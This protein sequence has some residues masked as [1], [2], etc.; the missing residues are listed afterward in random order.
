MIEFSKYEG[1]GNDFVV[2]DARGWKRPIDTDVV[3]QICD[4]HRGIGADGIL[5]LWTHSTDG[6]EMKVQN[7]DGSDAGMCGNGMRCILRFLYDLDAVPDDT[8][9]LELVVSGEA[10]ACERVDPSTFLVV[11]GKPLTAHA[12][13]PEKATAGESLEFMVDQR[14]FSGRCH[15]FG[16]PHVTIFTDEDPMS[17]AQEFGPLLES[18]SDFVDR[19]NVGFARAHADGFETVVYERGVGITQACGSG[20]CAVGISAVRQGLAERNQWCAIELPGGTLDICVDEQDVV[21]MRGA[22]R[23]VFTGTWEG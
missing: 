23:K 2:V 19:V 14:I 11:M 16:N 5:A 3:R 1:A 8:N 18:H 4:R 10:Y 7:A 20:A 22:A 17:L 21:T 9:K 15:F 13:L 6:F 12:T